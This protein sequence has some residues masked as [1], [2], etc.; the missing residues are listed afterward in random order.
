MYF[1]NVETKKH[2]KVKILCTRMQIGD[3][4]ND[5]LKQGIQIATLYSYLSILV[6]RRNETSVF[7]F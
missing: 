7:L 3:P 1:N 6:N 2:R 4:S 5:R